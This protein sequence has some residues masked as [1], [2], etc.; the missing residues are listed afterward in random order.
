M[1]E[2]AAIG[3]AAPLWQPADNGHVRSALGSWSGRGRRM[4]P[5]TQFF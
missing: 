5:K 1:K 3:S 4:A 2:P